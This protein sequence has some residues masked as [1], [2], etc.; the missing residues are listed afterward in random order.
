[1]KTDLAYLTKDSDQ[2]T[3]V[4]V[5]LENTTKKLL[6]DDDFHTPYAELTSARAQVDAWRS[7]VRDNASNLLSSLKSIRQPCGYNSIDYKYVP[8]I[9]RDEGLGPQ[10]QARSALATYG[11]ADFRILTYDSLLRHFISFG[12]S[13]RTPNILVHSRDRYRMKHMH[14]LPE[15]AFGYLSPSDL[16][17]TEDQKTQLKAAGYSMDAWSAGKLLAG[18]GKMTSKEF[19]NGLGGSNDQGSGDK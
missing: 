3:L 12:H 13:R 17:L 15:S 11:G 9:G 18:K 10:E 2:W 6:R 1:M 8:I 5:E 7:F 14:H 16:E 19:M 4:L